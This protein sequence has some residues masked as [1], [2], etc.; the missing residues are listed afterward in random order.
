V[1]REILGLGGLYMAAVLVVPPLS[2]WLHVVHA[3]RLP[4]V[5]LM[6]IG[7]ARLQRQ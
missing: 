7:K 6:L 1:G 2:I 4:T 3:A 5:Q